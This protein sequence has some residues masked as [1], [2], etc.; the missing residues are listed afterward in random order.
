LPDVYV[1]L[2]VETDHSRVDREKRELERRLK[3]SGDVQGSALQADGN[4]SSEQP[5]EARVNREP[6]GEADGDAW[7]PATSTRT[8]TADEA[9][10]QNRVA[11]FI[12]NPG[13]GKT[14]LLKYFGVRHAEAL[15]MREETVLEASGA[16]IRPTR[17]PVYVRIADYVEKGAGLTLLDFS[18]TQAERLDEVSGRRLFEEWW[19]RGR[20]LLLLDGLDEIT[21][22][23]KRAAT[24]R[25]IERLLAESMRTGN[26]LLITSRVHGYRENPLQR[27]D[28]LSLCDMNDDQVS[29]F[30]RAWCVAIARETGSPRPDLEGEQKAAAILRAIETNHG[31]RDLAINPLLCVLVALIRHANV[32]LPE[33]RAKLM[34]KATELLLQIWRLAQTNADEG[35]ASRLIITVEEEAHVVRPLALWM[36]RYRSSGVASELEIEDQIVQGLSKMRGT[37]PGYDEGRQVS[38]FLNRI[39]VHSGILIERGQG[40]FGF[41]HLLFEEYLCGL[42]LVDDP[43]KSI[44][45]LRADRHDPRWE[46]PIRLG[47]AMLPKGHAAQLIRKGILEESSPLEQV[48]HRDLALAARCLGDCEAVDPNLAAEVGGRI[49][50]VLVDPS[51]G[52]RI[53]PLRTLLCESAHGLT[54]HGSGERALLIPLLSALKDENSGVRREAAE[55]LRALGAGSETVLQALIGALKDED[56]GVRREAAEALGDLGPGSETVL[57]ALIDALKDENSDVRWAAVQAVRALGSGLETVLQALIGALK[58]ENSD[59]RWAAAEAL[60]DLGPGSET[61]LQALIDALKDENSYVLGTA[62]NTLKKLSMRLEQ[63]QSR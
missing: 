6:I 52:A 23:E 10:A 31:V 33:R 27:A 56:S 19:S 57:Q 28:V 3:K 46:E 30:F 48:L 50:A 2:T 51:Q 41:I 22:P 36:H 61:V 17:L 40:F 47:I 9:L 38:D 58:D 14:T 55:A 32:V 5:Y 60:G 37:E 12:G 20:A 1:N 25:E 24:N 18:R 4:H 45:L 43:D 44:A 11:V 34:Q 35:G 7:S 8:V 59:V 63:P 49:A 62:W 13:S 53:S 26:Q 42:E 54:L 21:A 16:P 29:R 15:R 39:R